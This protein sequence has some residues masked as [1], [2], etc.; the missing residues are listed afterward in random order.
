VFTG[1]TYSA[2]EFAILRTH[3]NTGF[4]PQTFATPRHDATWRTFPIAE[5]LVGGA[6]A[7]F[8]ARTRL[9]FS[10]LLMGQG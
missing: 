2:K 8:F 3:R 1:E 6:E 5:G 7:G 4:T 10:M 9:L